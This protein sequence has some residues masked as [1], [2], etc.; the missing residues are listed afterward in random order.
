MS[1]VFAFFIRRIATSILVLVL[2][3]MVLMGVVQLM[4]GD[5]VDMLL[6]G[7]SPTAVSQETLDAM[8]RELGLDLP[9]W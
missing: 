9:V 4:P 7:I 2:I 1:R 3:S 8:R 5:A 6:R